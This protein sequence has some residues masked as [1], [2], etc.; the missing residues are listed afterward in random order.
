MSAMAH[1]GPKKDCTKEQDAIT[2]PKK[3]TITED[4]K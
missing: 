4:G 2:Q 1:S 3:C